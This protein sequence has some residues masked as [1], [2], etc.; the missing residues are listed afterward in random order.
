MDK[1]NFNVIKKTYDDFRNSLII[2]INNKDKNL[3]TQNS[4][5]CYLIEESWND[6][7][8]KSL[9]NSKDSSDYI[10]LPK[11]FTFINNFNE[12]IAHLKD[13]KKLNLINKKFIDLLCQN[14]NNLKN[15]P[16]IKYYG[17]NNKIIIEYKDKKNDNAI[18]II[19]PLNQ[20]PIINNIFIISIKNKDKLLLFK[21]LFSE[22]NNSNI[23]SNP[24]Y[25]KIIISLNNTEDI[26]KKDIIKILINIFYFQ[27][28]LKDEKEKS[29]NEN[30]NYYLINIDWFN[31]FLEYYDYQVFIKSMS[32]FAIQNPKINYIKLDK[33]ISKCVE[34]LSKKSLNFK[35]EKIEDIS[36]ITKIFEKKKK[37]ND[38][39]S[40][41]NCYIM[42]YNIILL[43]N[44]CIL[45]YKILSSYIKKIYIKKKDIYFIDFNSIIIGNLH[46]ELIIPKYILSYLSK[47]ILNSE[48]EVFSSNEIEDYII[49]RNCVINKNDYK[50]QNL[51]NNNKIIGQFIPLMNSN[52][53]KCKSYK[54]IPNPKNTNFNTENNNKKQ[55]ILSPVLNNNQLNPSKKTNNN[56]SKDLSKNEAETGINQ[57]APNIYK[58][59][60]VINNTI[61]NNNKVNKKKNI[62][63]QKKRN[64]DSNHIE[65][66][67]EF[68]NL[69][70]TEFI[71]CRQKNNI[72]S[73]Q[74]DIEIKEENNY[75]ETNKESIVID[76]NNLEKIIQEKDELKK[77]LIEKEEIIDNLK[78]KIKN[79]EKELENQKNIYNESIIEQNK[80]INNKKDYE[81][82]IEKIKKLSKEKDNEIKNLKEENKKQKII[83]EKKKNLEKNYKDIENKLKNK[84]KELQNQIKINNE[85]KE[86]N[87]EKEKEIINLNEKYITIQKDLENLIKKEK[88]YK[89][90]NKEILHNNEKL[91]QDNLELR[92][93]ISEYEQKNNKYNHIESLL[94]KYSEIPEKDIENKIKEKNQISKDIDKNETLNE[95]N[96]QNP[97][98]KI[99]KIDL[100]TN[101]LKKIDTLY[102]EKAQDKNI[103][104]FLSLYTKPTLIGLKEIENESYMNATLQCLSQTIDLTKY[105]FKNQNEI[106]NNINMALSPA[107][108]ELLKKL[109][110]INGPKSFSPNDFKNKIEKISPIFKKKEF[111]Y[112]NNFLISIIAQMHKELSKNINFNNQS[113][114]EETNQPLNP[115]DKKNVLNCFLYEFKKDCSIISGLFYGIL[116]TNNVCLNCKNYY[117]SKGL[118]YQISY[119]YQKFNYIYFP[120]ETIKNIKNNLE[121]Y[122]FNNQL[123][124]K[125]EITLYDCFK[126]YLKT[127]TFNQINKTYCNMCRQLSVFEY[128]SKIYSCSNY[129]ILG[130][131]RD[132]NNAKLEIDEFLD[133]TE[134]ISQKDSSK[135]TYSLYGIIS[136]VTMNLKSHYIA[137]CKSEIDS[138]WYRYNNDIVSP[139]MNF[140]EEVIYYGKPFI[141]FYKRDNIKINV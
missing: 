20:N 91:K 7:L 38:N 5:D 11:N 128:S 116:E 137:S 49:S 140:K 133:I 62:L 65:S 93:K 99:F 29:F 84:E 27:K 107:Y 112:N 81:K 120:L 82:E 134:I 96:I 58:P 54:K 75:F 121:P 123:I 15:I 97:I 67:S 76:E 87:K 60:K 10:T 8:L 90:L 117:N 33:N 53:V 124:Q 109:W 43:I 12:I 100:K 70:K 39:F 130:L 86:I 127:E 30:N 139:I 114:N 125:N 94:R 26:F 92:N 136:E 1:V 80:L 9:Y 122:Y 59:K 126:Y 17:G 141:L 83:I 50:E 101:N 88:E 74:H 28:Y 103:D 44:K 55:T 132:G 47:E 79:I 129:L 102:V 71:D 25:K 45:Q 95:N 23:T 37:I 48:K 73:N 89:L 14:E 78:D 52:L 108:L 115:Y 2:N 41:N 85:T 111:E 3:F 66:Q 51:I 104:S 110:E 61:Q 35:K 113:Y 69:N 56:N 68:I 118:N 24:K 19:D 31:K 131:I 18:L 16:I 106:S 72:L 64:K 105:F 36:D 22:E 135:I 13:G 63:I 4:E 57:T 98:Y 138:K 42:P 6:E 32:N 119:N 77:K 34:N 46:E 40:F 21:D